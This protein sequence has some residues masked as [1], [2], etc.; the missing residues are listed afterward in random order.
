MRAALFLVPACLATGCASPQTGFPS[1]AP[2]ASEAIDPRV[3][4]AEPVA[5]GTADPRLAER[6]EVLVAQAVA[7]D[8]AFQA[9]ADDARR[10]AAAAG[11]RESE[12]W[13]VAQQALSIAVGERAPVTRAVGEIDALGAQ[14]IMA[15]GG[16]APANLAAITAAAA[17][18]AEIDDRQAASI[19]GIQAAL[20]R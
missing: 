8:R 5:A 13:V 17:R 10:L 14:R 7:G 9:A 16:I 19:S 11:P 1:L 6:L 12:S 18:V 3:P 20:R 2:R 4:V 15:T